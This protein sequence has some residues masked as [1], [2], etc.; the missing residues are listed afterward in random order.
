MLIVLS[1]PS[2][3][4]TNRVRYTMLKPSNLH[5][6]A[7]T[8]GKMGTNKFGIFAENILKTNFSENNLL[9]V[10]SWRPF[11]NTEFIKCH[12]QDTKNVAIEIIPE[13]AT[14]EVQPLDVFGFRQWKAFDKYVCDYIRIKHIDM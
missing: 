13:G 7:T 2:G 8:S 12:L 9:V 5:A 14:G 1:E 3:K 11:K 6:C 4:F 10:D